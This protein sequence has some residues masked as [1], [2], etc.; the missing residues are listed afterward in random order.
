[1][2][3]LD[4][5]Q[6]RLLGQNM[7]GREFPVVLGNQRDYDRIRA[8]YDL[9]PKAMSAKAFTFHPVMRQ[10]GSFINS[11]VL[12]KDD[13]PFSEVVNSGCNEWVKPYIMKK[14]SSSLVIEASG[15]FGEVA[16]NRALEELGYN[17]HKAA[18]TY[19]NEW[20]LTTQAIKR[21][22]NKE[23]LFNQAAYVTWIVTEESDMMD[24]VDKRQL[25]A[26]E[27]ISLALKAANQKEPDMKR[28]ISAYSIDPKRLGLIAVRQL[29]PRKQFA[30]I[31][32]LIIRKFIYLIPS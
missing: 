8:S 4:Y 22:E 17:F 20:Y 6:Q 24:T 23:N 32:Y 14:N 31:D 29:D 1:M 10:D 9:P 15:L 7:L 21:L 2:R 27:L 11:T 12:I 26:D 3:I 19:G 18:K 28:K 30:P 13:E 5:V 16:C 25:T